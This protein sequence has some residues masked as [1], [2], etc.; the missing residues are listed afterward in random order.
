MCDPYQKYVVNDRVDVWMIG[1]MLYTLCFYKQ[2]FQE[3][4]K[5][6]VINAAYTFPKDHSYPEKLI[7]IIRMALTPNPKHRPSIFELS[8]IF[9]DYFAIESI[10]LNVY[11]CFKVRIIEFY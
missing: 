9:N 6:S 11:T 4:S 2:P 10:Q 8:D 5:L 7:D 3:A 1:C